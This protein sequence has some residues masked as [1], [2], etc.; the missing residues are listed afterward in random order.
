LNLTSAGAATYTLPMALVSG[1]NS[2]TATAGTDTVTFSTAGTIDVSGT[3]RS[4]INS[5][6][7]ASGTNSITIGASQTVAGASSGTGTDTISFTGANAAAFGNIGNMRAGTDTVSVTGNTAVSRTLPAGMVSV[8]VITFANTT[9]DVSITTVDENVEDTSSMT[10]TASSLT[11]GKLTFDGNAEAS[12]AFSVTGGAAADTIIGGGGSDTLIGG[13]GSDSLTGGAGNDSLDGGAGADYLLGGDGN[14]TIVGGAGNDQIEPGVGVDVIY[15]TSTA[16][17]ATT[18][19]DRIVF[20][21]GTA[22]NGQPATAA[23]AG[24][25]TIVGLVDGSTRVVSSS[26]VLS[27]SGVDII[28]GFGTTAQLAVEGLR[29]SANNADLSLN[30]TILRS[31]DVMSGSADVSSQGLVRG[32]YDAAAGTFTVSLTGTSSIYFYDAD[33]S[34]SVSIR[35]V[36]LVGYVDA[37]ANDTGGTTGLIGVGG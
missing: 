27:V 37:A 8:E 36:V 12:G 32:T 4:D 1:A 23:T 31:G 34:A 20:A 29:N 7:L 22:V 11:D 33:P 15:L 6:V 16:G 14:D 13:S 9:T 25:N 28:H 17:E 18:V 35:G 24:M 19:A 26:A 21:A 5:F 2:V 30:S 3:G 10:V